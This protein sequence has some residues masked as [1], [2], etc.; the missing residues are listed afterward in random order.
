MFKNWLIRIATDLKSLNLKTHS[1]RMCSVL[2][3]ICLMHKLSTANHL[4]GAIPPEDISG[5]F[6]M[7]RLWPDIAKSSCRDLQFLLS[8]IPDNVI[9]YAAKALLFFTDHILPLSRL[10][11][12]HV[13]PLIHFFLGEVKPFDPPKLS[14]Q[15]IKW[16]DQQI[17]LA[18][19]KLFTTI[20][21]SK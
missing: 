1:D 16:I 11:W 10:D 13:I 7:L 17:P 21:I 3:I 20:S 19:V 4:Q 2:I 9:K 6:S 18:K 8:F 14:L 12:I 5:L 15:E